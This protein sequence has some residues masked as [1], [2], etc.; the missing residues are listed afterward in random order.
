MYKIGQAAKLLDVKPFV[1]RFWEGEFKDVLVPVRTP[2]GQRAYTESNVAT[3]R[4]IKR[5]LYEEGLTIEGA[6]KRL[7]QPQGAAK[8]A[9]KGVAPESALPGAQPGAQSGATTG[10][11]GAQ[12]TPQS[13][14]QPSAEPHHPAAPASAVPLPLLSAAPAADAATTIAQAE[15]ARATHLSATLTAT[16]EDVAREL[17]AIRDLLT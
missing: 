3:V 16:L 10:A 5:L 4:E 7:G 14:A 12:N 2:A 15:A 11:P 1:L 8:V 9:A 17:K 13:P 6:K